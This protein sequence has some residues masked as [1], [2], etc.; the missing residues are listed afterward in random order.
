MA[1]T[2]RYKGKL[3]HSDDWLYGDRDYKNIECCKSQQMGA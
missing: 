2:R 1:G 3:V